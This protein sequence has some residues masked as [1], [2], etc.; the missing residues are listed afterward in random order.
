[1]AGKIV[2][3]VGLL[4]GLHYDAP[5][6]VLALLVAVWQVVYFFVGDVSLSSP[7]VT[8]RKLVWLLALFLLR[9]APEPT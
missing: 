4:I 9:Q 3:G 8:L 5:L 7:L 1:M 2:W 6:V